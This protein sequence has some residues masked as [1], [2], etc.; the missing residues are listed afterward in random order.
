MTTGKRASVVAGKESAPQRSG[1]NNGDRTN[2]SNAV[3]G[4][5]KERVRMVIR[6]PLPGM[7]HI[8]QQ[9]CVLHLDSTTSN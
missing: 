5:G 7:V 8:V 2:T 1:E 3:N 9:S 6:T 4:F